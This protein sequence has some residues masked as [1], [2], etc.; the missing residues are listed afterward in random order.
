ML[1]KIES[2]DKTLFLTFDDG[3]D[4]DYTPAVLDVLACYGVPATFFCIGSQVE[5][6]PGVVREIRELGHTVGN[7]TWSHPYLTK[8]TEA[9]LIDEIVRTAT[10]I[11]NILGLR[12]KLMRPPYGD[13]NGNVLKLV[14]DLGCH[15][16]MWDVDSVDWSGIKGP[17][18]VS[19]VIPYLQSGSIL[20]HHSA[21]QAFGT[22]EALPYIIET[23]R[24]MGYCFASIS[25][26]IGVQVYE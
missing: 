5:K 26:H 18:I 8:V 24:K 12:P 7:H 2:H 9:E 20:L 3:P 11:E 19:N 17:R 14:W 15:V 23:A 10:A 25:E 4:S 6:H 13:V 16:V 22:P 21:G 1:K